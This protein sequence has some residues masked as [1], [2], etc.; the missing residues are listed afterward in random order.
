[1]EKKKP[2]GTVLIKAAMILDFLSTKHE[3]NLQEISSGTNLTNST[4]LKILDTLVLI[5]YVDRND[6]KI[7]RLGGKLIRYANQSFEQLNLLELTQP[8]LEKLQDTI[9]ETIH[10]G[11]LADNEIFYINKLEPRNQTIRMSSKIGITRPLY[12]SAMGKAMLAEFS[13]IDLENYLSITSLIP[14]T[15]E[16]ITNPLK[17]KSELESVRKEQVA[18]DDEEVEKDIFCIGATIMNGSEILGAFSI[19][20]PKYRL[21]EKIKEEYI[22]AIQDMKI[23]IETFIQ[24]DSTV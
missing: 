21:N 12:N 16:T 2:Y 19:S 3:A 4:A 13:T 14:Y 1:M 9:D 7:Y 5:G 11:I 23:N 20:M 22:R 10:L 6:E 15:E 17:L 18:F 24:N 8:F